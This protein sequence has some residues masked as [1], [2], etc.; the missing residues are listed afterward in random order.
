[1]VANDNGVPQSQ[2]KP[3]A[4]TSNSAKKLAQRTMPKWELDTRERVRLAIRKYAVPLQGL[5][6]RDANEGDTRLFV[7][8]FLFE[9]LGFDKYTDLTTE[10]M[11]KGDFADYGIRID[12]QMVAFIE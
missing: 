3:N 2:D 5:L 10:Y 1:M 4:A 11:V 8:D 7:T 9:G 6:D 12:K